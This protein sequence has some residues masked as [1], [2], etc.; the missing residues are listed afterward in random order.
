[1]NIIA[2]GLSSKDTILR[3]FDNR[4]G[5]SSKLKEYYQDIDLKKYQLSVKIEETFSK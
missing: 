5:W 3:R 2:D 1:M 4:D